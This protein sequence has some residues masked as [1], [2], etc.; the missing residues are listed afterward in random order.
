[1]MRRLV[2]RHRGILPIDTVEGIWRV[3]ISTFTYV[4]APFSVHADLSLGE[5]AMRDSARFHFGF[6]VPYVSHFSA[7]A[8]VEAVAVG[9]AR[10]DG[11]RGDA[12]GAGGA[13]ALGVGDRVLMLEHATY[14]VI[15]PEGCAAILWK[16]AARKKD[17]A[18]ALRLTAGDLKEFDVIDE[19]IPEPPG[20]AHA[21]PA[22][23]YPCTPSRGR[24]DAWRLG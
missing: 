22:A 6:T 8:A 16:D 4:Q 23:D 14:S 15:S 5:S 7:P 11:D 1:M 20:G 2:Q 10:A 12:A 17:A 19:I 3:I 18:E 9:V 21:D 24:C 13:L